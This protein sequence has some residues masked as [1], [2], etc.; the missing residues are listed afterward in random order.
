MSDADTQIV[1]SF[2]MAGAPLVTTM[3]VVAVSPQLEIGEYLKV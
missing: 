2:N 1:L 3:V